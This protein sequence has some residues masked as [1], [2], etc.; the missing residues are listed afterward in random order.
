MW[1]I[2]DNNAKKG[3]FPLLGCV[4]CATGKSTVYP[5]MLGVVALTNV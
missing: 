4:D 3:D 5:R 2:F 1:Q